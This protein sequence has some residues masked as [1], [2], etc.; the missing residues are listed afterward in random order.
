MCKIIKAVPIDESMQT[1]NLVSCIVPVLNEKDTIH[2]F[3]LS[4]SQQ[5]YRPIE[6]LIVDGGSR[7]DTIILV[8]KAMKDLNDESFKIKLFEEREFGTIASPAN[9]RNI[10]IDH[11]TG[12]YIFFI[13]SDTCF[14]E[15]F[16]IS[17]AINEMGDQNIII[18]NFKPLIDTKLEKYISKTKK[19]DGIIVYR[20]KMIDKVRFIPTLGFGEDR[21]FI[22]RLFGGFDFSR[23]IQCTLFIGRHYPHTKDELRKQTEWYGRT[24]IRFIQAI[25]PLNKKEFIKQSSYIIY[26]LLMTFLP[27]VILGS[28]VILPELAFILITLFFMHILMLFFKYRY[29]TIDGFIFLIWYSLYNALFFTKGLIS[30]IYKKEIIGRT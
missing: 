20:K 25:Y 18:I 29:K 28:L 8:N 21:E 26:N 17:A 9:A 2:N 5:D 13:D 1:K 22:Y 6:L 12:E 19:P 14:I 3:I 11:A 24:I 16:T 7:D 23:V 4:L 27:L 15:K 30:N 10:G